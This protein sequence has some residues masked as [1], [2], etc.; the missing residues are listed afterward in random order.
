MDEIDEE[1]RRVYLSCLSFME[2]HLN[3]MLR[4]RR[5]ENGTYQVEAVVNQALQESLLLTLSWSEPARGMIYAVRVP[6]IT[7]SE[8]VKTYR[9]GEA[10]ILRNQLP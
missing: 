1:Q 3:R 7:L 2:V 8:P 5:S 4:A 10:Y 6:T 9:P